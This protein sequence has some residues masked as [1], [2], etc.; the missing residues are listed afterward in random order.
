MCTSLDKLPCGTKFLRVLIFAGLFAIRKNKFPQ[1][2]ITANIFSAKINSTTT[3][4][5]YIY[6][7]TS[8]EGENAIDNS[9]ENTSSG[10]L[11]IIDPLEGRVTL[12][13][14]SY[15][16]HVVLSAF[17]LHVLK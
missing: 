15:R 1:N 9:V 3:C 12:I 4:I 10:T 11:V 13:N 17:R 14:L 2:K 16:S 7:N 8:V 5:E 6:K